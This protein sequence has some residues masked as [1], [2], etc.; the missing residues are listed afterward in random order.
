MNTAPELTASVIVPSYRGSHRLPRLLSSFEHQSLP[1]DRFEV[2]VVINGLVDDSAAIVDAAARGVPS[3]PS[4]LDRNQ[5]ASASSYGGALLA[6]HH[7]AATFSLVRQT[8]EEIVPEDIMCG[9]SSWAPR[10]DN[11]LT[12]AVSSQC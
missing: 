7:R 4:V 8:R 12:S 11:E 1:T 6:W 2:P 3:L 10:A 5:E 9:H